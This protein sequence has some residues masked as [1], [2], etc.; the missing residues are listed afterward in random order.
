MA[1]KGV[2]GAA[3]AA[4]SDFEHFEAGD[5]IEAVDRVGVRAGLTRRGLFTPIMCLLV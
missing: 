1:S 3:V 2:K 4:E 5:V